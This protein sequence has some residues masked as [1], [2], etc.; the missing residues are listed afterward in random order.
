[1]QIKT[2]EKP[3]TIVDEKDYPSGDLPEFL[4]VGRSNVGKSSLI[5]SLLGR[6]N[7]A[8]TSQNPGKTRTLNFYRINER[9][10]I[11]DVPGYGYARVSKKQRAEFAM[12]IERY[13]TTRENLRHIFVLVDLRHSVSEDDLLM[14]EYLGHLGLPFTILATKADKISKNQRPR[15]MKTLQKELSLSDAT[16]I[17]PYS[18]VTHENKDRILSLIE[19]H[20]QSA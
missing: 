20:L 1:M 9:F 18:S 11:V 17:I 16:E 2:V 19:H 15:H 7:I 14:T 3:I 6:K 4:F 12:M 10:H 13:L 5:N 8:Y